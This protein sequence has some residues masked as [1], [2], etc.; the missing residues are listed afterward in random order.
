MRF[1]RVCG[2][3][4]FAVVA[5]S[6]QQANTFSAGM[7][8]DG[9]NGPTYP[10]FITFR[11]NSQSAI[12][13]NGFPNLPYA[14]FAS[15]TGLVTAGATTYFGD[16]WD[17]PVPANPAAYVSTAVYDG[18]RQPQYFSTDGGGT[19]T[20]LVNI[21]GS[22]TGPGLIPIGSN[23][24][25]Q[26]VIVDPTSP[27]GLSLT[28]ATQ[29]TATQGPITLMP[30]LT[31]NGDE[32][33]ATIQLSTYSIPSIPFYGVSATYAHICS[34]GYVSLTTSSAAPAA[35]FTA[36]PGEFV[37]QPAKI[38]IFWTDLD[39]AL[40]TLTVTLDANPPGLP[41]FIDIAY[42]SFIDFGGNGF[43]HNFS[44]RADASGVVSMTHPISNNTSIYDVLV[45]IG[46]GG[47][48]QP[49]GNPGG[50][51]LMKDL[52]VLNGT[53]AVGLPNENFFEWFGLTS[54]PNY[55]GQPADRPYDLFGQVLTWFP[56]GPGALPQ[57][58]STYILL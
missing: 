10:M 50:N 23:Y 15:P 7:T 4:A 12:V 38:A 58:T 6:A 11:T 17:L 2:V 35:D 8:I 9:N 52:S 18:F 16:I 51:N 28:A 34:N 32:G 1:V 46:P 56:I 27:F 36:T 13:F 45:G 33:N 49:T 30:T 5:A 44:C 14:M 21:P 37:S 29:A 40:G 19:S 20:R 3:F 39:K 22:G 24:A 31:P 26:A 42:A 41:G 53:N 57:S 25:F 43:V 55:S 47:G 48:A 54:M